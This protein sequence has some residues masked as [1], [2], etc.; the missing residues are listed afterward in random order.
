VVFE[1][2]GERKQRFDAS[3]PFGLVL[4]CSSSRLLGPQTGA[5]YSATFRVLHQPSVCCAA[6]TPF[7]D[8]ATLSQELKVCS[9]LF[10]FSRAHFFRVTVLWTGR[11]GS[12]LVE[13]TVDRS[14]ISIQLY[15]DVPKDVPQSPTPAQRQ[16]SAT[17]R[18]V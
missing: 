1:V 12:L 4:P 5:P 9:F 13:A 2:N 10:F 8:F 18:N 14:G 7:L 16:L 11:L 6:L 3:S 15:D 17:R